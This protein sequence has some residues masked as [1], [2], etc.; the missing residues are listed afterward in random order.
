M[1]VPEPDSACIDNE[2]CPVK[3]SGKGLIIR[4]FKCGTILGAG[5]ETFKH[6]QKLFSHGLAE[7]QSQ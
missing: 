2:Q 3:G 1:I 7:Y 5:K 6:A 4:F